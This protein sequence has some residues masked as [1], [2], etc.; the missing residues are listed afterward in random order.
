MPCKGRSKN[1]NT[2]MKPETATVITVTLLLAASALCVGARHVADRQHAS[3]AARSGKAG[4]LD[5]GPEES[6]KTLK[7]VWTPALPSDPDAMTARLRALAR[8]S[9]EADRNR[10]VLELIPPLKDGDWPL[11]LETL[12]KI[13]VVW[14]TNGHGLILSAW[15]ETDPQAAM[16]WVRKEKGEGSESYVVQAWLGKDPDAALAFLKTLSKDLSTINQLILARGIGSLGGDLPR[17][18]ELLMA[19]PEG[20]CRFLTQQSRVRLSGLPAE[21]LCAWADSFE[22]IRRKA[23]MELV[24]DNLEGMEAKL[25]LAQRFPDDI[26]PEKYASIYVEWAKSD[27]AAALAALESIEPGPTHQAVLGGVLLG[28]NAKRKAPEMFAL[29]RRWP[30]EIMD[31]FLA[32]L[33]LDAGTEHAALSLAETPR[34]KSEPLRLNRY[35]IVLGDWFRTDPEAARKWLAENEVP[36]QVRKEFEGK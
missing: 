26:A 2:E 15:S 36:E 25:A 4:T 18:S 31:G 22:G 1:L 7:V 32:D 20:H 3:A 30:E 8:T 23:V 10:V 14:G 29:T 33:I 34:I 6:R 5:R 24:L 9:N 16:A 35:S 28:L 12:G 19:V 13:G 27:E 21:T 11:V 17:I